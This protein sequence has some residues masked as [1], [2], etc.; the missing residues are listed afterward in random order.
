MA[1]TAF[2]FRLQRVLEYREMEEKWAKDHFLEKQAARY[3]AESELNEIDRTRRTF[4]GMGA[5]DLTQRR[6]LE[7][8]LQKLDDNERAQRLLIYTLQ[9]EED[10]ARSVW[11]DKRQEKSVMEKLRERA[12]DEFKTIMERR[13][14][15]ALDEF[16]T[17]QRVAA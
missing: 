10:E 1:E 7:L 9:E 2:Q 12:Y 8:R 14:Q 15:N 16:A 3:E 4:L 13:E 6:E 5:D 17:Q 11:L